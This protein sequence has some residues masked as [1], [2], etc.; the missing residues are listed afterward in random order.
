MHYPDC[1]CKCEACEPRT[2][3]VNPV[4]VPLDEEELAKRIGP[5][6]EFHHGDLIDRLEFLQK[7]HGDGHPVF[8]ND[9]DVV[10]WQ[11]TSVEFVKGTNGMPNR[12]VIS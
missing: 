11:V 5:L 3:T 10:S 2:H 9:A 6:A 12:I 1:D 7:I 8:V 4:I